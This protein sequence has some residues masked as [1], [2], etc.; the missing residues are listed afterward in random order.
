MKLQLRIKLICFLFLSL[1]FSVYAQEENDKALN[2]EGLNS[3]EHIISI[4][5]SGLA[6]NPIGDNFANKALDFKYGYNLDLNYTLPF[7]L[8]VG[9]K[10]QF[11]RANPSE[12]NL[13]G[14]YDRTNINTYGFNLGYLFQLSDKFELEP[15]FTI[16]YTSYHNKKDYSANY[17]GRIKFRDE[18]TTIL[19]S[20]SLNYHFSKTVSVFLQPDY[21]IDF[22]N[23][24]TASEIQE[25][26]DRAAYLNVQIGVKFN[27]PFK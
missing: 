17:G 8:I 13:I 20:T 5:L 22:M 10:Y 7:R 11:M 15:F 4:K 6:L 1:F 27:F 24:E 9:F 18:A 19:F 16:A 25:F 21:R 23:V 2:D 12:I 26:F 3:N 14:D